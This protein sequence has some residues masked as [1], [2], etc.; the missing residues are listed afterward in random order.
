[1]AKVSA[2]VVAAGTSSR[3]G[4]TNK[5]FLNYQGKT[6]IQSVIENIIASNPNEVV[7]VG[8]ELSMERLA[9]F[10]YGSIRL[11]ENKDYQRGM[12]SSIQR[13]VESS[14]ADADGFMICLGEKF[15]H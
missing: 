14:K 12:T 6:I 1:M 4:D 3:M 9:S 11:V 5:L 13:G 15:R 10:N 7:V 2:I 8:S